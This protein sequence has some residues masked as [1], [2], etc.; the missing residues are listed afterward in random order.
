[1]ST[2]VR[3]GRVVTASEDFVG[4]LRIENG[5]IVEIGVGLPADGAEVIDARG[6]LV[7]PGGVDI[8]THLDM[9]F[10]ATFSSDDFETGHIA[11]AAG[12]TTTHIDFALQVKGESLG[13]TLNRWSAK[14]QGK[15]VIDYSFHAAITDLSEEVMAEIPKVIAQGFTSF[16]LFMAYKGAFQ[17]DDET[18]F[19]VLELAGEHGGLTMVHAENGD[20]IDVLQK[21]FVRAG[22]TDP[23]YH[24]LS[25]PPEIE[26]EATNRAIALAEIAKAPL[27]V[28]HV[29]C[30]QAV[31]AIE[32]A[33][34]RGSAVF[35][36]TCQQYFFLSYEDLCR[37]GFEGAK[38]VCSP[39]F[40]EK[41]HQEVLWDAVTRNILQVVSSDHAPFHY[42]AQKELGKGDFTKIPN[43][44]PTIE[45]RCDLVYTGGVHEGR[46]DL[47]RFVA[48]TATEPA[49][50]FGLFP[51]KGT[52]AV[53]SDADLVLRDPKTT[54]TIAQRTQ[55]MKTDYNPFEGRKVFGVPKLVM[56]RGE[57]LFRDRRYVGDAKGKGQLVRRARLDRKGVAEPLR[58]ETAAVDSR[59][60]S[61]SGVTSG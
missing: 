54:R 28:V 10:F 48:L 57:V 61:H 16:K 15:A 46:F 47:H 33:R 17:V 41:R 56:R 18:L 31:R 42:K 49:K 14:A 3:N 52:I 44:C 40:R 4:D 12:G 60:E 2:I 36:E 25:R 23:K 51:K 20:V 39:P 59:S 37:P 26:G 38:F 53:G 21:R 9:P 8:H 22:K 45:D 50:R 24:A 35:G 6:L 27:Y 55:F 30:E 7:V 13:Q 5:V 34:E 43:G 32:A 58:N 29:T 19:R 1:M 11:A